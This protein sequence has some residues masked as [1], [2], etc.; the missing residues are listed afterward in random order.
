MSSEQKQ[1]LFRIIASALLL[2]VS[3]FIPGVAKLVLLAAALIISG[4]DVIWNAI[5]GIF[6]G[7]LLD[8][9]FLMSIA[10]ICAFAI[11]EYHEGVIVMIFYQIG[12]LFCDC[13]VDM[14]RESVKK[15]LDVRAEF[16]RVIENCKERLCDPGDVSVGEIIEIRPGERVPLDCVITSGETSFDTASLTGE[17]MPKDAGEGYEA[18]GGFI[19]L[20]GVIQCR[21]SR[22]FSKS[23]SARILNLIENSAEN[24][25]RRESFIHRFSMFYTPIVVILALLVAFVPPF[26]DADFTKWI[27][28]ALIF[29]VVSCPCALVISVPLTFYSAIGKASSRGILIKGGGIVETLAKVKSVAFDKTGTITEGKFAVADVFPVGVSRDELIRLSASAECK[30]THPIAKSL[31]SA[32]NGEYDEPTEIHEI[33]G[34]GVRAVINGAEVIC[35]NALL[36]EDSGIEYVPQS[37]GTVVYTASN[38]KFLGSIIID[39]SIRKT[40]K[41]AVFKL[42]QLGIS[43]LVML[44][45]DNEASAKRVADTVEIGH[46]ASLLPEDKVEKV[47]ELKKTASPVCFVGDGMNDSPVIAVSDVG[48]AMGGIGSDATVEASDAVIMDDNL[49]KLPEAIEISRKAVII[50]K[51]NIV[52]SIAVKVIVMVLGT[53]GIATMWHAVFADVGVSVIAILNAIRLLK[54]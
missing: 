38:G 18:L 29:L 17:S 40:S 7:E 4:Y 46:C 19:N 3:F 41:S 42:K 33:A 30:S 8:E 2:G 12:E 52:F 5:C 51:E 27:S 10:A 35:G 11:G 15:L 34:R 22:V 47:A 28:R 6:K 44:T 37:V 45:G 20:S 53:M 49:E 39:D 13:A 26:F 21:V 24:K 50:A 54:K 14:S 48:I 23:A 9:H 36:M 43:E 1:I 25:S 32:S 31:M 16:A